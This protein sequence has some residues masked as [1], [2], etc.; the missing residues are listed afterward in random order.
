MKAIR[1]GEMFRLKTDVG[2]DVFRRENDDRAPVWECERIRVT[3]LRHEPPL[4]KPE[5][6]SYTFGTEQ[7]WFAQRGLFAFPS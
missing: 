1:E 6:E 7:E 2:H 4:K 3:H 5:F